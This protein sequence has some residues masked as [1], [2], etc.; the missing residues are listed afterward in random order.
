[1]RYILLLAAFLIFTGIISP[2]HAGD[3]HFDATKKCDAFEY[4]CNH[5][6][7][8]KLFNDDAD[9]EDR[10]KSAKPQDAVEPRDMFDPPK[11]SSSIGD[12][13]REQLKPR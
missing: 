2:A 8:K 6:R 11:K 13:T 7:D 12:T 3:N 9:K 10:S 4:D 1:M 5:P